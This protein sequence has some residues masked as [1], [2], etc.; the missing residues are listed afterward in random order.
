LS[1]QH[2]VSLYSHLGRAVIQAICPCKY[3][4]L[5]SRWHSLYINY[6]TNITTSTLKHKAYGFLKETHYFLIC[7]SVLIVSY[8]VINKE[9][10]F[11]S[12]FTLS[13]RFNRVYHCA[14][15]K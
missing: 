9:G 10:N 5:V 11:S 1:K 8:L 4:V 12:L 3:S 13:N 6:S 15:C 7:N 14:K 2:H